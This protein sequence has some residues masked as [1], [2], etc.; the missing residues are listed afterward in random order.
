MNTI[1]R[2]FLGADFRCQ[3]KGL[4]QIMADAGFKNIINLN[5]GLEDLLGAGGKIG[6]ACLLAV[7][8]S[9]A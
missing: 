7:L 1:K 6:V 8:L 3:Q 2:V 4:R 5:G 9:A